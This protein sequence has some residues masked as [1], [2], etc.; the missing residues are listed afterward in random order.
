M[1][2]DDDVPMLKLL[3]QMIDWEQLQLKVVAATYSSVKAVHLFQQT[4]PDIV[5]TD[6]GLP[7]TNGIELAEQFRHIKPEVRVIF[8]TCHEDFNYARQ[9]LK[10]HADDYLIKDQLTAEQLQQSLSKSLCSL[11]KQSSSVSVQ[12][13]SYNRQLFKQGLLQS[14]LDRTN[15]DEILK[16]AAGIGIRWNCPW[17]MLSLV[18]VQYASYDEHYSQQ[19]LSLICYAI[20]NIAEELAR[21]Y[22]GITPFLQQQHLVIV[23]NYHDNL[24]ANNVLHFNGYLQK[25]KARVAQYM[26]LRLVSVTVSDKLQLKQLG[27]CYHSLLRHKYEFYVEESMLIDR[28]QAMRPTWL[29]LP[30]G[31]LDNYKDELKQALA[32][33]DI[34]GIRRIIRDMKHHF[35]ARMIEPASFMHELQACLR[36]LTI[37]ASVRLDEAI[38][39]YMEQS[40]TLDDVLA[41]AERP[42]TAM[43]MPSEKQGRQGR[44][45]LAGGY[46][47]KLQ[48][49]QHYIEENLAESI[50]SID[51]ARHLFLNPSYFSRYFKRLTGSNFTDYVH[52]FKMNIASQ[53]LKTSG[54]TLEQ[55]ALALGYSDRTYF[56]KVF[57]KYMGVT[58]SEYK[59]ECS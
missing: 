18:H 22:E 11:K 54:H 14:V 26:K 10:L 44:G 9:A 45:Q 31:E 7:Q 13:S 8:L 23:Y 56:S 35:Q 37:A 20:Y 24:A 43:A 1:L 46:E 32:I 40:R 30:S 53:M 49:I 27:T 5:I 15:V 21:E 38:Y 39:D 29:Q 52:Q 57:K 42:L 3:Q 4:V 25:L 48:Q 2:I 47:P 36:E 28:Q 58:P 6:I 33:H 50:T 51:I 34:D 16:Y 12:P 59:N 55:I 41:L 17:C 19:S